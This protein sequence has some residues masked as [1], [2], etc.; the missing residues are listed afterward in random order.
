[1]MLLQ[2]EYFSNTIRNIRELSIDD[3]KQR[4]R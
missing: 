3:G 1:M 2:D 4:G